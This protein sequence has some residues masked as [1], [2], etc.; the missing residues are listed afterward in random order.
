MELINKQNKYGRTALDIAKEKGNDSCYNFLREVVSPNR[1]NDKK[2][3]GRLN[4]D[5]KQTPDRLDCDKY[6]EGVWIR[7]LSS[8]N[9]HNCQPH[10]FHSIQNQVDLGLVRWSVLSCPRVSRMIW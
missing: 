2:I 6:A 3:H 5:P 10:H 9:I 4:D 7:I 1:F 8:L